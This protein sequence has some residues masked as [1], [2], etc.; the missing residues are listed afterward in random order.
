M[1]L[2]PGVT[3]AGRVLQTLHC[4]WNCL[5]LG[6]AGDGGP[7]AAQEM[8]RFCEH[9][10]HGLLVLFCFCRQLG[11][12]PCEN[13]LHQETADHP[14]CGQSASQGLFFNGAEDLNG[15]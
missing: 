6:L 15:P 8:R 13:L 2:I 4:G 14:N 10:I 7:G 1:F 12:S 3:H 11:K 9:I 5:T